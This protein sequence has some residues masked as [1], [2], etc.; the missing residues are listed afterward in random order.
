M[1]TSERDR[2]LRTS[3]C[4]CDIARRDV[5]VTLWE[6]GGPEADCPHIYATWMC[7]L[8]FGQDDAACTCII[9]EQQ[10]LK[11]EEEGLV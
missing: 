5:T 7:R 10:R 8:L 9:E 3:T 2:E 11:E 4:Y 6:F 1:D